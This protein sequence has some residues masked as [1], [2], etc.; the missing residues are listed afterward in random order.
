MLDLPLV[1]ESATLIRE[2]LAAG[3]SVRYLVPEPVYRYI[4]EHG[5]VPAMTRRQPAV[6][7]SLGGVPRPRAG[8]RPTARRCSSST[9]TCSISRST[10]SLRACAPHGIAVGYAGKAFLCAAFA[11]HLAATPLRLDVCS[12]GELVTAERGGFP[13]GRM[14]FH[15]CGKTDEELRAIVDRRVAFD[16]ID[17]RE[18]L[19]RLAAIAL[20]VGAGRRDAAAQHRHRGAHPRLHSH[21]R[22]EH[23]V[24]D[25]ARPISRRRWRASP[26]CR[27]CG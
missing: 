27:S 7:R 4:E 21:R 16:V 11:E 10:A 6:D 15:G 12:L 26:S 23:E 25:R 22:R 3:R 1:A 9:S 13:A 17:N 2:R 5:S 19:E 24:R 18:E 14:Y 20:A 8:R